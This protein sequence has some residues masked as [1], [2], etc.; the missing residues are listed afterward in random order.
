MQNKYIYLCLIFIGIH[1]LLHGE[2][3]EYYTEDPLNTPFSISSSKEISKQVEIRMPQK[4][5]LLISFSRKGH[6]FKKLTKLIGGVLPSDRDGIMIP[7]QWSLIDKKSNKVL[8]NK[9]ENTHGG[10]SFSRKHIERYI[11]TITVPSGIY[12]INA[13]TINPLKQFQ[14]IKTR[15]KLPYNIKNGS[16]WHTGYIWWGMIFNF[17]ISPFIAF[18]MF[19]KLYYNYINRLT[20]HS[21]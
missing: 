18:Y 13:K 6:D 21:S 3:V 19:Y 10:Q 5:E 11:D 9:I 14:N 1:Y 20:R 16:T 15:I 7:I 8:L 12:I 17:F 4:Y 2:F